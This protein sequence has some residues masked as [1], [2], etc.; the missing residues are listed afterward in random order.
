[1]SKNTSTNSITYAEIFETAPS[2]F[3]MCLILR[4]LAISARPV[5]DRLENGTYICSK[6]SIAELTNMVNELDKI[7]YAIRIHLD[8]MATLS[9]LRQIFPPTPTKNKEQEEKE[10]ELPI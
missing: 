4:Q 7:V 3:N 2:D 6:A 1:M 5:I 10:E 9:D 8:A